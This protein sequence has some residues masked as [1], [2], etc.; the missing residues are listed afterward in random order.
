[1]TD[2]GRTR[3]QHDLEELLFVGEPSR[4][5]L[6]RIG[7]PAIFAR[8]VLEAAQSVA[9]AGDAGTVAAAARDAAERLTAAVYEN[10]D[11]GKERAAALLGDHVANRRT[12]ELS[13]EPRDRKA[14]I[15]EMHDEL[16]RRT[17]ERA[18]KPRLR[19][20]ESPEEREAR[21]NERLLDAGLGGPE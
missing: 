7:C 12:V 16:K 18:L 1:M 17:E 13:D 6:R 8:R 21:I 14:R 9:E 15:A 4:T 2:Q 19:S 10:H 20:G 5:E 3:F 11:A